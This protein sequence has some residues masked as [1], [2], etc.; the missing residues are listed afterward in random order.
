MGRLD[1]VGV[2]FSYLM[3]GMGNVGSFCLMLL[4]MCETASLCMDIL[5]LTRG[6]CVE[7]DNLLASWGAGGLLVKRVQPGKYRVGSL[8]NTV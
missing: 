1:D 8:R 6:L 4:D 3:Q 2:L 7:V 5:D